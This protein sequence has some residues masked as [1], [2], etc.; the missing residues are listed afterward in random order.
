MDKTAPNNR[1]IEARYAAAARHP[2]TLRR[3]AT[4]KKKTDR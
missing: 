2:E 3:F 4:K 1:E